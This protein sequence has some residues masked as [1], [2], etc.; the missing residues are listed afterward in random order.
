MMS[1]VREQEPDWLRMV[2]VIEVLGPMTE[3]GVAAIFRPMLRSV[4]RC[5]NTFG[6]S[7]LDSFTIHSFR[8]YSPHRIKAS[9]SSVRQHQP[10]TG[11]S[12]Y[13]DT[14]GKHMSYAMG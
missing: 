4:T 6:L 7:V 8:V 9:R 3:P 10:L 11:F 13:I 2:D 5:N 12:H 1:V 14:I